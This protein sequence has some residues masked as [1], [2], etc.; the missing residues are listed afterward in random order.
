MADRPGGVGV[1]LWV[2]GTASFA[3]GQVDLS[4]AGSAWLWTGGVTHSLDR[5]FL[6][7]S[8]GTSPVHRAGNA[9]ASVWI[10][11]GAMVLTV[12]VVVLVGLTARGL[13]SAWAPVAVSGLATAWQA[14]SYLVVMR[15]VHFVQTPR[16]GNGML[17]SLAGVVL[18]AAAALRAKSTAQPSTAHRTRDPL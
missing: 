16:P 12:T 10:W 13:V 14:G 4:L 2:G 5:G 11:P 6:A 17:A 8:D 1:L 15:Q 9:I 7:V 18:L 3:L